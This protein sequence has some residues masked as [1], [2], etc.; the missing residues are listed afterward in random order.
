VSAS[1]PSLGPLELVEAEQAELAG[2][3]LGECSAWA[4]QSLF[5]HDRNSLERRMMLDQGT[6]AG[7]RS[8]IRPPGPKPS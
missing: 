1:G 6:E 5:G 4:T 2:D 7:L 8:S 3:H